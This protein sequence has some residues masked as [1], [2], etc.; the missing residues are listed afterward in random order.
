MRLNANRGDRVALTLW[1]GRFPMEVMAGTKGTRGEP[2]RTDT[3]SRK[4]RTLGRH[5]AGDEHVRLRVLR[6][7]VS[8]RENHAAGDQSMLD[9]ADSLNAAGFRPR[10]KRERLVFS[11]ATVRGMLENPVYVGDITHHGDVIG[12][13]RHEPIISRKL[14][15]KVQQV[16]NERARRP[17]VYGHA[18]GAPTCFR[19]WPSARPAGCLFGRIRPPAGVTT[20]TVARLVVEERTAPT[21]PSIAVRNILK[22]RRA[23]CSHAWSCRQPGASASRN[24]SARVA[25]ALT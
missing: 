19:V 4:E 1:R 23:A 16:R 11:K 2:V 12:R 9:I 3:G 5:R 17:Q 15:E 20:T 13:G 21:P 6:T 7:S 24:S 10:S 14:W 25:Q 22:T 8:R 18:Q